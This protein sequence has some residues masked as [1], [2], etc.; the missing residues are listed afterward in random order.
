MKKT[1]AAAAAA[2][3]LLCACGQKPIEDGEY[4]PAQTEIQVENVQPAE[5]TTTVKYS[6][7]YM[8]MSIALPDGWGYEI[9]QSG[10]SEEE[11]DI[12]EEPEPFGICFWPEES[13]ETEFRLLYTPDGIGLCGTGITSEDISLDSGLE[14]VR[15][16][17]EYEGGMEWVMYIFDNVPG[18]YSLE[19]LLSAEAAEK[20]G[21]ALEKMLESVKLGDGIMSRA[22]AEK[23][24]AEEFGREYENA[25]GRFDFIL[26]VWDVSFYDSDYN[27]IGCL[28]VDQDGNISKTP[29]Q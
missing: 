8:N 27:I 12:T 10:V 4:V 21:P 7:R 23:L 25:I 3:V 24:A 20:Y 5:E 1:V 11:P 6:S 29:G 13:P 17:E 9:I 19:Y 14:A 26:G 16:S 22:S 28:R 18:T 15:N 2:M